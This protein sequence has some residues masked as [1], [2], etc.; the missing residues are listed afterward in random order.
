MLTDEDVRCSMREASSN[1]N[2]GSA[3]IKLKEILNDNLR[4]MT[5]NMGGKNAVSNSGKRGVKITEILNEDVGITSSTNKMYSPNG[6]ISRVKLNQI[7]NDK[8]EFY[9]NGGTPSC[10][11]RPLTSWL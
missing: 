6:S 7:L 4:I 10:N 9:C 2:N 1:I 3:G 8:I 5:H 11:N